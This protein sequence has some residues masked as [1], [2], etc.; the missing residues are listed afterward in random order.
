[1]ATREDAGE[2]W[3]EMVLAKESQVGILD[4]GDGFED[5]TEREMRS[6]GH[7]VVGKREI[8]G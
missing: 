8:G 3:L 6:S 1:M 2:G 4:I 7:V 5:D